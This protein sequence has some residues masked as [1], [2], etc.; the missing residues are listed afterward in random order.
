[1]TSVF[2]LIEWRRVAAIAIP[3]IAVL[4]A[5]PL[6]LGS[7]ATHVVTLSFYYVI[8]AASWNLLAGMTGQF[9]LAHQTFAAIGAYTSGLLVVRQRE[10]PLSLIHI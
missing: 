6:A 1:M 4:A 5:L 9:S 3:L 7:Y 8:L 2:G 10:L